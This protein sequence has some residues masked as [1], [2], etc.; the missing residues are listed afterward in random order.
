[1]KKITS[2]YILFFFS[3]YLIAQNIAPIVNDI[4][5]SAFQG[6]SVIIKLADASLDIEGSNLTFLIETNP[7]NAS[8]DLN[9][10]TGEVTYTATLNFSGNDTFTY[11]AF[12]G[13]DESA[14]ATVTINVIG[15][16]NSAPLSSDAFLTTIENIPVQL[17]LNTV[18]DDLNGDSLT[19]TIVT[20]PQN[21]D[22]IVTNEGLLTYTPN[23]GFSGTD[24]LSFRSNDGELN[25]N[26]AELTIIVNETPNSAPVANAA[27][28]TTEQN[29]SVEFSIN[30][31]DS[32]FDLLTLT[33][34][35]QT[36]NGGT[37]TYDNSTAPTFDSGTTSFTA[38]Y[39]P[40]SDYMGTETVNFSVSDGSETSSAVIT[41]LVTK[42]T[43]S[44]PQLVNKR[45]KI[46]YNSVNVDLGISIIDPDGDSLS[47]SEYPTTLENGSVSFST[48]DQIFR[49]TPDNKFV[50]TD[51][52]TF[53]SSDTSL[54]SPLS[55]IYI[56]V[57]GLAD[58]NGDKSV[59]TIDLVSLASN[60]VGISGYEMPQTFNNVYDVNQDGTINTIDLVYLASN[61]VGVSGYE[62]TLN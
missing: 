14:A 8:L 1:M 52:F 47:V 37:L 32:N 25:G 11:K 57:I 43:N 19:F 54:T 30:G 21:G 45:V 12:D 39:T 2:L 9:R 35:D 41:F 42:K 36:A 3:N 46:G 62:L 60:I 26:V 34:V 55:T 48:T 24:T 4:D 56:D 23:G 22:A 44:Q 7:E 29:T 53:K 49:F 27:S 17:N 5:V 20:D 38:T 58:I 51:F 59:N 50:G 10:S 18:S 28:I 61:L 13:V 6:Q 31:F 40:A 16:P 15:L 33:L